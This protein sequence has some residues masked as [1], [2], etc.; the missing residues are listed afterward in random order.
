M[1]YDYDIA[2]FLEGWVVSDV[3]ADLAPSANLAETQAVSIF[4]EHAAD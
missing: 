2:A 4:R 1:F 3:A